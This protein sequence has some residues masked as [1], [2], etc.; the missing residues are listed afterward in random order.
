MLKMYFYFTI[1]IK[2]LFK[3]A[4]H[5]CVKKSAYRYDLK[6]LLAWFSAGIPTTGGTCTPGSRQ[7]GPRG[8][9]E[10]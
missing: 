8:C 6:I 10:S 1:L 5:I 7:R 2:M 9:K 3:T 4:K